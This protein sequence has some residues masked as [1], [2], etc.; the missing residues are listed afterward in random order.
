MHT[1]KVIAGA[2]ILLAFLIGT[3]R[4]FGVKGSFVAAVARWFIPLWFLGA[5]INMYVGIS[6]A[7]YTFLEELPMFFVVFGVP[8]LAAGLLWWR[9]RFKAN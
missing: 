3:A 2:F 5:A 7:G 8:S 9:T 4:A 6:H 1:L